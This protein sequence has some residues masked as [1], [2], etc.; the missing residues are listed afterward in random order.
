[1]SYYT[2]FF[3]QIKLIPS[4]E[5][6]L[7]IQEILTYL[8]YNIS[9]CSDDKEKEILKWKKEIP[10]LRCPRW[11][12]METNFIASSS[13]YGLFLTID[14]SK[15]G[16]N[17]E[18]GEIKEFMKMMLPYVDWPFHRTGYCGWKRYE[19]E[20]NERPLFLKEG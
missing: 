1:M 20:E 19:D 12:R 7:K 15:E 13:K 14:R 10:F 2:F 11:D 9:G 17:Q 8:N 4:I 5:I 16:L 18:Q 6:P 3:I